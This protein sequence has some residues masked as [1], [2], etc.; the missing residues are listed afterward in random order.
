[1]RNAK[2]LLERIKVRDTSESQSSI[3]QVVDHWG[4]NPLL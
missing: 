3:T 1:M 2:N 4:M